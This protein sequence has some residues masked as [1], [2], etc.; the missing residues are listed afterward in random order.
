ML[1]E[2]ATSLGEAIAKT[3]IPT[4]LTPLVGRE[5]EVEEACLLLQRPEVRLLTFTGTGGIGKTRLSLHVARELRY[6]FP[7][8]IFFISLASVT[9]PDLVT[10]VVAQTLGLG[11]AG[12]RPL[13][14]RLKE[15]L[16]EKRVLL[17]LDNFEQVITVASEVVALL[18]AARQV[19]ILVT[20]RERLHRSGER[21]LAITIHAADSFWIVQ[22]FGRIEIINL[23]SDLGA[24]GAGIKAG[25]PAHS[26]AGTTHTVPEP[27]S[28]VPDWCDCAKA[29][30]NHPLRSVHSCVLSVA[31]LLPVA[32]VLLLQ[33]LL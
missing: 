18:A 7:D 12:E 9:E 3:N 2:P 1:D 23:G 19:K 31:G 29:G 28:R 30:Y 17:L 14:V 11:V 22:I 4:P 13:F 5:Q 6:D 33:P 24:E 10:L 20:S 26:R 32:L 8:G 21:E 16:A 27:V 15:F 25:D